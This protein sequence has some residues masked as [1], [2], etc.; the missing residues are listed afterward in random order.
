MAVVVT[1]VM[2][3]IIADSVGREQGSFSRTRFPLQQPHDYL[4]LQCPGAI[5]RT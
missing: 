3:M 2:G 1:M 4:V 5:I